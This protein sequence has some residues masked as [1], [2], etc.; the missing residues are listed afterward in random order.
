MFEKVDIKT[1]RLE[2]L[3]GRVI[4]IKSYH[5]CCTELICAHDIASGET[6]IIKEIKH[7]VESGHI[8]SN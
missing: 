4:S 3:V 8:C 6:F 1:Y 5:S 7:T 2:D